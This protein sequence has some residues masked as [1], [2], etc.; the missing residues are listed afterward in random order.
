MLE[1]IIESVNDGLFWLIFLGELIPWVRLVLQVG[2]VGEIDQFSLTICSFFAELCWLI[3][4]KF[5]RLMTFCECMSFTCPYSYVIN[6]HSCFCRGKVWIGV[7][8]YIGADFKY[9]VLWG[10]HVSEHMF[11]ECFACTAHA[12]VLSRSS[13]L[14]VHMQTHY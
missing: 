6:R 8:T 5:V 14:R 1:L 3:L 12:I 4:F 13:H 2:E 11:L 7:P 10:V 9:Y